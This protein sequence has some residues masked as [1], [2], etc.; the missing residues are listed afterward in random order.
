MMADQKKPNGIPNSI[1]DLLVNDLFKK[2]GINT[3][4][5]KDQITDDK[6]QA[7]RDLVEDLSKQVDTFLNSNNT[8]KN[9]S[10][11]K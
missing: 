3:E 10:T 9:S 8:K 7:I 2:N 4:E 11:D 1:I 6:K 5:V